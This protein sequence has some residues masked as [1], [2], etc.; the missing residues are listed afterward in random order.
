MVTLHKQP[1]GATDMAKNATHKIHTGY[2]KTGKDR[3]AYFASLD[4][5][6]EA[7]SEIFKRTGII[8]AIVEA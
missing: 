2:T 1:N 4:D 5:A 3:W 8:V 7:V 6:R